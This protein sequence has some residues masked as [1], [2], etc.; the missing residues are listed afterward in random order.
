MTFCVT[1]EDVLFTH[2]IDIDSQSTQTM[3]KEFSEEDIA[4]HSTPH[5]LWLAINDKVYDFTDFAP[6]H[7]GGAESELSTAF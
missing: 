5:D 2:C 6:D 4:V 1:E 3:S 7:P